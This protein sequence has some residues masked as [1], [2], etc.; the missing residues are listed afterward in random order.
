MAPRVPSRPISSDPP[1]AKARTEDRSPS[2]EGIAALL[3][4]V[5]V[6]FRE[7]LELFNEFLAHNELGS[8]LRPLWEIFEEAN[9]A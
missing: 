7:D 8:A 1:P 5:A 9:P 2:C 3:A 4:E 6:N